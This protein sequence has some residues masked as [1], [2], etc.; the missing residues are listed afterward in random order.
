MPAS[1]GNKSHSSANTFSLWKKK[2]LLNEQDANK[3]RNIEKFINE[4]ILIGPLLF[5][6]NRKHMTVKCL[7]NILSSC[8][9]FVIHCLAPVLRAKSGER[10]QYQQVPKLQFGVE[11]HRG[12]LHIVVAQQMLSI[13]KRQNCSVNLYL[14]CNGRLPF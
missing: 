6:G 14:K 4:M 5:L 12:R 3:N 13:K 8:Y 1:G 11:K 2:H 10:N 7:P 9:P